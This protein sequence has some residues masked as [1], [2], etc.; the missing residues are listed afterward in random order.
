MDKLEESISL[1]VDIERERDSKLYD[2]KGMF[3]LE[4]FGGE[5]G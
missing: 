4:S 2:G 3:M 5:G 1:R